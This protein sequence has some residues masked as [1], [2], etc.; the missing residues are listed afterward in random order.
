M[1]NVVAEQ[2]RR[3]HAE[4]I[5]RMRQ[6]RQQDI[7]LRAPPPKFPVRSL[8]LTQTSTPTTT[9]PQPTGLANIGNTCYLNSVLQCLRNCR[10]LSRYLL[11]VAFDRD[12]MCFINRKAMERAFL[13]EFRNLMMRMGAG[14]ANGGSVAPNEFMK[15]LV[16]FDRNFGG[17]VQCDAQECLNSIL[18]TLHV[19]LRLNVRITVEN[20]G[21]SG[22]ATEHT[23]FGRMRK[24]IRQYESHL[25]HDGYSAI[26]DIFGSQFESRITCDRCGHVWATFDPYSLVPVEIDRKG[27]TL[28]DCLDRFMSVEHL[29]DVMCER[30]SGP[31]RTKT[32]AVKQ[33]RLWTLPKVLVVQL[34]RFD[35]TMRKIDTFIQVPKVLNLSK[36]VSHPRVASQ[37]HNNPAA[38]QLYNL[39]GV[40]CHS[41]RLHGGHYTAKCLRDAEAPHPAGWYS[42]NDQYVHRI[43]D[44][45]VDATLQSPQNYI[46][47]YEIDP[48]TAR[49]WQDS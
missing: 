20:D 45:A 48:A 33:F 9:P 27:L 12:K 19:A 36:Y 4:R 26:E 32:T 17:G 22:G 42:F 3:Q 15:L 5:R 34:K 41:G 16:M 14:D 18:Q 49:F 24:G 11:G 40:V 38:L 44:E 47:F 46:M 13:A 43:P 31:E 28:Y 35:H 25:L 6:V 21:G 30:C 10:P 2:K 8:A 1:R 39:R 7:A 37:V 29:E 23:A